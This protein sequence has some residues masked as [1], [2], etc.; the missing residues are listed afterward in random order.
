[1]L[2]QDHHVHLYGC[3]TAEDLWQMGRESCRRDPNWVGWF[4][5]E[6][7]KVFRRPAQIDDYWKSAQG[8]ELLCED[9]QLDRIPA[10]FEEFQA[11]FNLIIALVPKNPESTYVLDLILKRVNSL[12]LDYFEPR[13]VFPLR[14]SKQDALGC[15]DACVQTMRAFQE[16]GA[17]KVK[18][19]IS[20]PR[21][22]DLFLKQLSW[23]VAW[24]RVARNQQFVAGIDVAFDE[25]FSPPSVWKE[26]MVERICPLKDEF[27][28][29]LSYHVA[30]EF[31]DKSIWS[32]IRWV[33]E[34]WELGWTSLG[35]ATALGI[36][37]RH[38]QGCDFQQNH[39]ESLAHRNWLLAYADELAEH[40]YVVDEDRFESARAAQVFTSTYTREDILD[41]QKLQLAV[42]QMLKQ[43]RVVIESCP[44]SNLVIGKVSD[45]A[46]H[47]LRFFHNQQLTVK[48]G[49][50]DPGVFAT[51]W[52]K[53]AGLIKRI[54]SAEV[55]GT[56]PAE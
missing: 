37:P 25:R 33:F 18:L 28:W 45:L 47:P 6:Y 20:F 16:V 30:E 13:I 34:S 26:Q 31:S 17:T 40:G 27:G 2:K 50:D 39:Q 7:F 12:G 54:L 41:I 46:A 53:E 1:M 14:W 3:L 8:F 22:L 49:T 38:L 4:K 15:L 32:A 29:D 51:D 19:K 52:H 10:S 35:H 24:A 11:C 23:L 55:C 48:Y 43:R 36:C 56:G 21:R 44:S 5:D 42:A 9:Y